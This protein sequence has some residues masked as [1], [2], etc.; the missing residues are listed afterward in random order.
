MV[1]IGGRVTTVSL[2]GIDYYLSGLDPWL[3]G[4]EVFDM[5]AMEWKEGYDPTAAPYVTPD[6]VKAYY[7]LYGRS[8]SSWTHEVV[9]NWFTKTEFNYSMSATS[10]TPAPTSTGLSISSSG[11][12]GDSSITITTPRSSSTGLSA[13]SSSNTDASTT[14]QM[15][16]SSSTDSLVASSSNAGVIAGGTIGVVA[17]LIFTA[18]LA[19]FLL[20]RQICGR[21]SMLRLSD[22]GYRKSELGYSGLKS[23]RGVTY[24]PSELQGFNGPNKISG[25]DNP[26]EMQGTNYLR[27]LPQENIAPVELA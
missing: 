7:R 6:A 4:L 25:I 20:R 17:A 24:P 27:E 13:S 9:R 3:Q 10:S 19:Y 26:I 2:Q 16:L 1:T 8:P 22:L 15:P 14:F 21:R 18:V 5:S 12:T 11:N 23:L